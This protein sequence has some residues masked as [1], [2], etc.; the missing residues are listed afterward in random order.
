MGCIDGDWNVGWTASMVLIYIHLYISV[1]TFLLDLSF[2]TVPVCIFRLCL[3]VPVCSGLR[4]F[5]NQCNQPNPTNAKPP[6][7]PRQN[8]GQRSGSIWLNLRDISTNHTTFLPEVGSLVPPTMNQSILPTHKVTHLVRGHPLPTYK[9]T[10]WPWSGLVW[11]GLTL[12]KLSSA[13]YHS[14][15]QSAQ[16]GRT[17]PRQGQYTTR[18]S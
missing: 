2:S 16:T 3:P 6:E 15:V 12:G 17:N 5:P 9:S 1:V 7:P 18:I 11:P 13:I 4:H 8:L 10:P 14:S